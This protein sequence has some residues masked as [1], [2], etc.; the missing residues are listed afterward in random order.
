MGKSRKPCTVRLATCVVSAKPSSTHTTRSS[1]HTSRSKI[2]SSSTLKKRVFTLTHHTPHTTHTQTRKHVTV[3]FALHIEFLLLM[4]NNNNTFPL[5]RDILM[6]SMLIDLLLLLLL[7]LLCP[8][9]Q[10]RG[11]Q[12]S[13]NTP[14]PVNHHPHLHLLLL[15][16]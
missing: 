9:W 8:T 13:T 14:F 2:L 4:T 12:E 5:P 3:K 15:L 11:H 16:H 6:F 10:V 1:T 7:L